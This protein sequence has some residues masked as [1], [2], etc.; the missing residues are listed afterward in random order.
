MISR[1]FATRA[2]RVL[3]HAVLIFGVIVFTTPLLWLV[4]TS[5]KSDEQVVDVSSLSRILIPHPVKWSNYPAALQYINYAR[6][7]LNTVFVTFMSVLG[8][9]LS[10]SLVAYAFARLSWPGRDAAFL[11]LLSTMMLPYQVTMIPLFLIFTRI[12][13]VN[14]LRP[15]WIGAFFAPA[16]YVFL[17]RQFFLTIPKDLE[18][19]AKID[20]C[21]YFGIYARVMLPLI[22]PAVISVVIFQF[23]AAWNDFLGPLIY[24]QDRDLATLSLALQAFQSI[25]GAEWS[26]L[27]AACTMMILP[28]IALFLAAQRYFIQ[29][30]TLTG[31]KA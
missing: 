19:A 17:L 29:G 3:H 20:G 24:I 30:V 8:V 18:D 27:M 16:F 26:L 15:L 5:L 7:L 25:H 4:A 28:V 23:M 21:G 6:A 10:C 9:V 1:K 14:T 31:L 11:L 13:W 12:G 22:K 2:L